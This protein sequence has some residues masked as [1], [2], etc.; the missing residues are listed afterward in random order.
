MTVWFS[1]S[2]VIP[3]LTVEWDLSS[4]QKAW[5]T[6]SVQLGFVFGALL[7]AFLNLPDRMDSKNLFSISAMLGAVFNF[8]IPVLNFG[9]AFVIFLR[10]LTGITLAG[11]YP[12]AM[13]IMTTWCKEDRGLWIGILIGAIT[14]GS[15]VPHI[16]NVI[17]VFGENG[18][19]HWRSI[20]FNTSVNSVI[21]AVI[22]FF[23]VKNGPFKIKTPPFNWKFA[24]E[25]L[26]N[27]PVR[28]ANFGYLGH[29]WELYAMW[30]WV[31]IFVIESYS[32]AGIGL[33]AARITGFGVIAIGAV[34]CFVAGKL[35]DKI[36]RTKI[37]SYSLLISGVCSIVAGFS[38]NFPYILTTICLIWGF[39]VVADSAQFSAAVS[40]LC[41]PRYVGSALTIQTSL[42]F[43]LTI[44]TIQVI[45]SLL[46]YT[47]WTFVFII[48]V[49]GPVFGIASMLKLRKLPE[50]KLMA[51][52][53][54]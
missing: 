20:L 19:P 21:A 7:S 28:L 41:D 50:A 44:V 31:P 37:T 1:A 18:L 10:F 34:G 36:G 9:P 54:R 3:Q 13:K 42:G 25:A 35:A 39:A 11:V 27:Q 26:R 15:A 49:L 40:E 16:L 51:S 45:P 43:L 2:A 52:G 6:I 14:F 12:P 32:N 48:L 38:F 29:M 46:E 4:A 33:K 53:N 24:I 17:P 30:T 47:S 23:F 22:A 8:L 5:V